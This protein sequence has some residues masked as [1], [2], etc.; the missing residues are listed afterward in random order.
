MTSPQATVLTFDVTTE[1]GTVV[2]DDGSV[3]PFSTAAFAL[4]GLR[5]LR[6]G[7]RV[8]LDLDESG[9]VR[10]LTIATMDEP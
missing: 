8:R 4:G 2:M 1:A 5:L 3:R 6:P 7:Q 10:A 9:G